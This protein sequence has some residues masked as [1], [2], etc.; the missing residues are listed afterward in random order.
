MVESVLGAEPRNAGR[1]ELDAV[2]SPSPAIW[3]GSKSGS[4]IAAAIS[5]KNRSK[6]P[7]E[8]ISRIRQGA[9]S[10]DAGAWLEIEDPGERLRR[11]LSELYG[12][13]EWAEP[14]LS[15]VIRDAPLVS[16]IAP[17]AESFERAFQGLQAALMDG[18]RHRGRAGVRVSA[19]IGHAL[20]FG[21]WRSL[22]RD[23]G[24]SASETVD[25]MVALVDAAGRPRDA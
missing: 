6:P 25:L 11:A 13:Y 2:A 8:M 16:A 5:S 24:L 12:W 7:G 14:M 4:C 10:P 1:I 15:N 22:A 18:R 19:A 3:L 20:D 21:T 9:S 17:A 23:R